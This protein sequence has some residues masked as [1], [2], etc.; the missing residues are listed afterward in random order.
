MH[1]KVPG[2]DKRLGFAITT[3]FRDKAYRFNS[4]CCHGKHN[5]EKLSSI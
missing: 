2:S 4:R 3:K 1:K 5:H